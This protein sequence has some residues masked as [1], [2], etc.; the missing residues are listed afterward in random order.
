MVQRSR[1][2]LLEILG[3]CLRPQRSPCWTCQRQLSVNMV[4]HRVLL[5]KG[6][7]LQGRRELKMQFMMCPSAP[8]SNGWVHLMVPL[9]RCVSWFDTFD[10]R[11]VT[12]QIGPL[13]FQKHDLALKVPISWVDLEGEGK[14]F[15]YLSVKDTI[16]YLVAS[17][18]LGKLIGDAPFEPATVKPM[19][20]EF[21]RRYSYQFPDFAALQPRASGDFSLSRAVPLF[22]HGD[23]G[24]GLRK[25]PVMLVAVQGCIGRGTHPF[26][27]RHPIA[28]IRK[29]KMGLNIGGGSFNSRLL[30]SAMS[31]KFYKNNVDPGPVEH[32]W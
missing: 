26:R 6:Y 1:M 17:G 4:V 19:L 25:S 16:S 13:R 20:S 9:F 5:F 12:F 10:P 30:F 31:K 27:S 11:H 32:F 21:W 15:P 28:S 18:N 14:S 2:S 3:E 8:F 29:R 24:R 7:Q 23:E 22:I